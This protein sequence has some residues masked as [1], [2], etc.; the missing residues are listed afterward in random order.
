VQRQIAFFKAQFGSVPSEWKSDN[1][2]VTFADFAISEKIGREIGQ[3]FPHDPFCSEEAL[4]ADEA[5]SLEKAYAWILDPIDGTNNYAL[6]LPFCGIS[7]GLFRNGRPVYGFVYDHA[8]DRLVEGG[9]AFGIQIQG[10]RFNR[11]SRALSPRASIIGMH[12]PVEVPLLRVLEPLLSVYRVRS[13]G[14]AALNLVYLALGQ[15]D[16]VIDFKVRIWD[17][18]AGLALLEGA[19]LD[20]EWLCDSPVPQ[21]RFSPDSPNLRFAAGT[22]S[23]LEA[24]SKLALNSGKR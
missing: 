8:L 15:F 20:L 9:G 1:T 16:G 6:G 7:L 4:P 17:I 18:A 14:S 21:T 23:F 5:V 10:S 22:P 12:F 11:P 3:S 19:G 2:R 13:Q 24:T